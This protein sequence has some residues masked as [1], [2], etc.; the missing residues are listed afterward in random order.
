M[1]WKT[2]NSLEKEITFFVKIRNYLE[3]NDPDGNDTNYPNAAYMYDDRLHNFTTKAFQKV[4]FQH[5]VRDWADEYD[6]SGIGKGVWTVSADGKWDID[7]DLSFQLAITIDPQ[8]GSNANSDD[9][10]PWN[11]SIGKLNAAMVG[12]IHLCK[13]PAGNTESLETSDV[14]GTHNPAGVAYNNQANPYLSIP[15]LQILQTRELL[16]QYNQFQD[17][18]NIQAFPQSGGGNGSITTTPTV[19]IPPPGGPAYVLGRN[20]NWDGYSNDNSIPTMGPTMHGLG[21]N[22][23]QLEY[24]V[25]GGPG[26]DYW[27]NIDNAHGE[28]KIKHVGALNPTVPVG[29]P[30]HST[31]RNN[32]Y[33]ISM[34]N[35]QLNQGDRIFVITSYGYFIYSPNILS[36]IKKEKGLSIVQWAGS[37]NKYRSFRSCC[38]VYLN[39][40]S[41]IAKRKTT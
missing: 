10:N 3:C 9:F 32:R 5:K 21:R 17:G 33:S 34:N 7:L 27:Y 14:W 18:N 26:T 19:Y 39:D 37:I 6:N 40:G 29:T 36:P 22:K 31:G 30:G 23:N 20:F 12:R 16:I 11:D 2:A 15:G 13:L 35:M 25:G 24:R 38:E 28:N 8:F 4:N 41:F 1:G